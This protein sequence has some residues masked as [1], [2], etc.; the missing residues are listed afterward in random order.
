M[1]HFLICFGLIF[2]LANVSVPWQSALA[3]DE[4]EG[5]APPI[6]VE[7]APEDIRPVQHGVSNIS[8]E[9]WQSARDQWIQLTL[10]Y[11]DGIIAL[12]AKTPAEVDV[13]F[14]MNK[15]TTDFLAKNEAGLKKAV[16]ILSDVSR[17][18]TD[19]QREEW[20]EYFKKKL[21]ESTKMREAQN[22]MYP[23]LYKLYNSENKPKGYRF[24]RSIRA[25][26]ELQLPII[27]EWIGNVD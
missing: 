16:S 26:F 20:A 14:Q 15:Y 6:F 3:Q 25:M 4:V 8:E 7:G 22:Y 2:I 12:V 23:C 19:A 21:F 27:Y 5:D 13:C 9:S 18:L 1:K 24:D 17:S 11:Y 10:S